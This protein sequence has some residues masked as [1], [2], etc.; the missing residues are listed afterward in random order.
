M[1]GRQVTRVPGLP[2]T[3]GAQV[4]VGAD[5]SADRPQVVPEVDDRRS[6]PEP[7]AVVDT[8]DHEPGLEHHRVR[9]H[10][11]VF[12]SVYSWM[13]RSFWTTRSGSER[14]GHW[15]PTDARNSWDA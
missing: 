6:P 9:D 4:E 12:G 5:L 3:R 11:V 1:E 13:S 8:V 2:E 7:V 14:N 15:A 10:R